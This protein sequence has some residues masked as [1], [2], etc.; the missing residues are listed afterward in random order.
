M[1][2]TMFELVVKTLIWFIRLFDLLL[3]RR[4]VYMTEDWGDQGSW[5]A[6]DSH[7]RKQLKIE[8]IQLLVMSNFYLVII[9]NNMSS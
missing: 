7:E 9:L 3:V 8:A 1:F 5:R 2:S 4:I 6:E